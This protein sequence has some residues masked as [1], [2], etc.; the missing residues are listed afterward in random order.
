MDRAFTTPHPYDVMAV[1]CGCTDGGAPAA[2][3]KERILNQ[4]RAWH[5][6]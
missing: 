5:A 4:S 2:G 1:V 6:V 3:L